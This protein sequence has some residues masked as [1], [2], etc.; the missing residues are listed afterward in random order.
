MRAFL[1][2]LVGALQ[3]VSPGAAEEVELLLESDGAPVED[4]V[5]GVVDELDALPGPTVVVLDDYHVV[6][7]AE[8]HAAVAFL[9][10]NLPPQVTVAMT[11][12]A[13]PPLP[14]ARL[15]ARGEL[16]EIRAADLRF[17]AQE[18][19]TFLNDVM[20]LRLEPDQVAALESRTE[21]WAVGLQLAALSAR[22]R[23]GRG[24]GTSDETASFIEAFT[25][26][27]RFVLDYLVE[28]VLDTLPVRARAFLLDTSVLDEL[29]GPLCDAVT[30]RDDGQE[31]LEELE[32]RNVFLVPLD[33]ERTWFRYH[34][35]FADALRS[36]ARAA[37]PDRVRRLHRA[38]S[39]WHTAHGTLAAA[40]DHALAGGDA[41]HAAGLVELALPGARRRRD[42]VRLR[43]WLN[44]LPDAVLSGSALLATQMVPARLSEGDLD[45][46]ERWL[47]LGDTALGRPAPA[48]S[49]RSPREGP[50]AEAAAARDDELRALP[51]QAAVYR[52]AVAQGRGDVEATAA[53]ARQALELARPQDHVARSGGSG[54]LGL[55]AWAAGDL[56]AAVEGFG[57]A[58]RSLRA[59][60]N[61]TDELGTTVV[62]ADLWLARGRPAQA[63]ELYEA[64]LAQAQT[65]P[66][67][68]VAVTGDLHVGL[69]G[70][71][72]EHGE[73]A[74]AEAHLQSA[75]ALGD[76]ASLPENRYRWFTTT[77]ALLVSS[78]DLPGAVAML[79][80]AEPAYR[81]GY[82]PDVRPI[83]ARRAQVQIAQGRLDLAQ[84]WAREN[85]VHVDDP[86]RFATE[87][88]HLVLGRL[89]VAQH[90][91][92]TGADG[93]EAALDLLDRLVEAAA[94]ADR[95]GSV[96][97]A[98]V[99]RALAHR[100]RGDVDAALED[101]GRSLA[102]AVP[103][104]YRRLFLDEGPVVRDLLRTAAARP[105]VPGA[106]EAAVLLQTAE[107][108]PGPGGR[109]L[110]EPPGGAGTLSGR[111][112][113]VLRLLATDLTG[114]EI[115]ERLYMSINTFRTHTRHIFTK[116]DVTTR[117][118]AVTRAGAAGVVQRS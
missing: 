76:R 7:A 102:A 70:V 32:R 83:G 72:R 12:R 98:L 85:Q 35:L 79:D 81:P 68:V 108:R 113:E 28:E 13:D 48:A 31:L 4:V 10:E 49:V 82:L 47:A 41:E 17:T 51:A 89:L 78:G 34:H 40:V 45:G 26:S 15:R 14:L 56:A 77:A 67:A 69:A 80:L 65:R 106:Q 1:A 63:R 24:G 58:V 92:G 117:R 52:A 18:A 39:G 55:A 62:L 87:Y 75:R 109:S 60:G 64:A 38:A 95:G 33:D 44:A 3:V 94:G 111:E 21:G 116:L 66:G 88:E 16:I 50:L 43:T 36:R 99:V 54:F 27:H 84:A 6:D 42:D 46:A 59:A 19:G 37:D 103:A 110:A 11:T 105:G 96:V 9:L 107:V 93:L 91:P 22:G 29:T 30:G 74:A 97:E 23:A 2:H 61:V 114:P 73:L 57:E 101:L 8:V 20:D 86:P 100:A 104:G 118:A 5:A 90:R 112:V 115:A 53:H 25:G 71:L